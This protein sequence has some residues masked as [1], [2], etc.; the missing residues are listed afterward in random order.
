MTTHPTCPRT[1]LTSTRAGVIAYWAT[2]VVLATECI[3]GGVMGGLQMS[4]FLDTATHLGYP[5]YFMSILGVWYVGAGIILLAPRLPRLKEW[6]YAGLVINYTG[7]AASHV[8][9]GDRATTLIG[10]AAFLVLTVASWAL[11]PPDRRDLPSAT[12]SPSRGRIVAYWVTTVAVAAELAL[13][14]VWDLLRTDYVRDV[15]EHLGYPTY[16]L[17]IMGVWKLPGA[18]VLLVPRFGRLREWVYAGAVINYTSAAAS[19]LLV[20][21]SPAV[22]IAPL[23]LLGLTIASW[24]LKP[25]AAESDIRNFGFRTAAVRS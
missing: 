9:M 18:I 16:L 1:E 4:P 25:T 15:V 21:D 14:G 11:R 24:A 19:H 22:I 7:A 17:T 13:G 5:A 3:I 2:T 20:G 8:W 12:G 23:A 10:P 6:A